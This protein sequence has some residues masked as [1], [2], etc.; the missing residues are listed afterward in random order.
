[1]HR[2][3]VFTALA[4]LPLLFLGAEVTTKQVGMVDPVWPTHPLYLFVEGTAWEKGIG[5]LIEHGHRLA[6]WTVGACAI[7]LAAGVWMTE[8]RR[9]VRWLALAALV[10]VAC[11]GI[12]GGLRVRLNAYFG[13]DLALI[14]GCFGQLV[15]SLLVSLAM[16]TSRRWTENS[17][18]ELPDSAPLRR[19]SLLVTSLLIL[20]LVLGAFVRHRGSA[21]GQ[22]GHLLVAFAAIAAVTWLVKMIWDHHSSERALVG[23]ARLLAIVVVI[24]VALGIE[25]WMVKFGSMQVLEPGHWLFNRDL[26]RTCHVLGGALL[27]ATS[28]VVTLRAHQRVVET[29]L[30]SA[31]ELPRRLEEAA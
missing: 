20:Q 4:A 31:A 26:V 17:M 15:F 6:G 28:V 11:Q 2:L 5:F 30:E 24:Q 16:C 10:G 22:R 9:W 7:V 8:P 13:T 29:A 23:A 3:A 21:I 25:A 18:T 14:H 12:L 19:W 27:L 1:V